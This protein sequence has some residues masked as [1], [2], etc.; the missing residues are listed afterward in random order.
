MIAPK[1]P[2]PAD[3]CIV[4][5]EVCDD[6]YTV[7]VDRVIAGETNIL[8]AGASLIEWYRASKPLR[9]YLE[10]NDGTHK[11]GVL[12][13]VFARSKKAQRCS[14]LRYCCWLEDL[15]LELEF[16]RFDGHFFTDEGECFSCRERGTRTRRNLGN[17]WLC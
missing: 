10:N 5:M 3:G 2:G 4:A 11:T 6:D 8:R 7:E 17:N 15:D 14:R 13:R 9:G 1:V 16:P 12:T